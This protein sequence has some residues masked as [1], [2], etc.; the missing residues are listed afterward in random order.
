MK[1]KITMDMLQGIGD[2]ELFRG[3]IEDS[4]EGLHINRTG[5]VLKYLVIKRYTEDWCVYVE[6][7]F[8]PMT[9]EEIRTNGDK[10]MASTAYAII[11]A[12]EEVWERYAG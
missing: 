1:H 11:D 5:K 6:D 9:Y 8:R 2:R 10:I 3:E 7:C 4:P 12:D